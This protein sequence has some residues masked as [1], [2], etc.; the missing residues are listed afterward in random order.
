MGSLVAPTIQIRLNCST[1]RHLDRTLDLVMASIM[2]A[3]SSL[4]TTDG[5]SLYLPDGLSGGSNDRYPNGGIDGTPNRLDTDSL[6]LL[7]RT[8]T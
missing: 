6:G 5:R 7:N 2:K 8:L 1:G 4:G 3:L